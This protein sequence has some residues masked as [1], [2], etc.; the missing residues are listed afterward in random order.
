MQALCLATANVL[1]GCDTS[2]R[3]II[4]GAGGI[5]SGIGGHLWRTGH[6]AILL[7]RAGHGG[8]IQGAGLRFI[9]G[10]GDYRLPVP[11]VTHPREIQFRAGDVV[12][13]TMKTHDTEVALRELRAA[14]ADPWGLP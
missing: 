1:L 11:A 10:T 7:G 14:G 12:L 5:G 6:D 2:M 13:L 3:F 9:T 8:Q 4:Y